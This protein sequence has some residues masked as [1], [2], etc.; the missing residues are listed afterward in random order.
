MQHTRSSSGVEARLKKHA[1]RKKALLEGISTAAGAAGGKGMMAKLMAKFV[2]NI[3][4]TR[5]AVFW[6]E[7]V[8]CSPW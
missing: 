6:G 2:D 7:G 3:Q 4:V 8:R 5:A 1:E